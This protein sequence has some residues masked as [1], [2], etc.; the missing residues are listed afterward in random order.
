MRSLTI[1]L[2][3]IS[4]CAAPPAEPPSVALAPYQ[5]PPASTPTPPAT[6]QPGTVRGLVRVFASNASGQSTGAAHEAETPKGLGGKQVTE[7]PTIPGE[8]VIGTHHVLDRREVLSRLESIAGLR[9]THGGWASEHLHRAICTEHGEPVSREALEAAI[10]RLTQAEAFRF[11]EPNFVAQPHFTP[12]D[13]LFSR[14]WHYRTMKLDL[15]W[16]ITRGA[17]NVVV[18][19]LDTGSGTNPDLTANTLP[20]ID[21]I[22]DVTTAADGDGR[23]LDPTDVLG[24]VPPQQRGSSW[25]G[26]H[27]AGTIAATTDNRLGVAGGAPNVR[28]FHVRVLGRGGGSTFDIATGITWAVGEAVPGLP[29]NQ[30]PAQVINMSLGGTGGTQTYASAVASAAA[31]GAIVVVAAGNEDADTATVQPCNNPGVIC[32]G[33]VDLRGNATGYTNYGREVTISAP[34]GAVDRDDDGNGDPDGVLSTFGDGTYRYL[35]GTSMATPHVAALVA[36]MK[37]QNRTLTH[38]Q[39]V[40]ALRANVTPIP[41]CPTSCGAGA[42]DAFRVMQAIAPRTARPGRLTVSTDALIFTETARSN[43]VRLMNTGDEP[44]AVRLLSTHS[45][46]SNFSW[47]ADT[48]PLPIAAGRSVDITIEYKAAITADAEVPAR[49]VVEGAG[50]ES[51]I[52]FRLRRP[53]T[54]PRTVVIVAKVLADDRLE[55]VAEATAAADGSFRVDAPAGQYLVFALVDENGDGTFADEEAWGV[56][57]NKQT[58]RL[59]EVTAGRFTDDVDFST[60]R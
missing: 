5:P 9:C 37:S 58:P 45:L 15:A 51:P 2:L 22:S 29:R 24:P 30:H 20:G 7:S 13:P 55:R 47:S 59:V 18:A 33:A 17:S 28:V 12:N 42:V 8:L 1:V 44:I 25:H 41:N 3:L 39:V 16:T 26:M 48:V 4:A 60:S 53:R 38:A 43:T 14:Q 36:L 35:E 19:V 6:P 40:A 11:V 57:P 31:A 27:V 21:L 50:T 49:F 32:V 46:I 54:P 23:D 34:G 10:E 56:F 52:A